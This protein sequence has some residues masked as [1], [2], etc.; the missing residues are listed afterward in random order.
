M[1]DRDEKVAREIADKYVHGAGAHKSACN[2]IATALRQAREEG[3]P[4]W[5]T[6]D[7]APRDV[8]IIVGRA[9]VPAGLATLPAYSGEAFWSDARQAWCFVSQYK[10][11]VLN[12]DRPTHWMP[13][14]TPPGDD[15]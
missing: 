7:T 13:L 12:Y 1:A 11:T 10:G 6:I 9:A 5:Q 8:R 14:P 15:K 2:A 3:R 4:D